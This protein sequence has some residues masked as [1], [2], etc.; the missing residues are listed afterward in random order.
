VQQCIKTDKSVKWKSI[1]FDALQN[2]TPELIAKSQR[3]VTFCCTYYSW[4]ENT[5]FCHAVQY[6]L[7]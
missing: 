3:F 6:N 2:K 4:K 5:E 1:Q 7:G